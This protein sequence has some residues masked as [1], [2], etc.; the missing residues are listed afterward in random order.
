MG[1]GPPVVECITHLRNEFKP[2]E[3]EAVVAEVSEE[4]RIMFRS[5]P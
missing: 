1:T 4:G 5:S 3:E 2:S